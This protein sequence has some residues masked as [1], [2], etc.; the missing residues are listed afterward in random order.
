MENI[1][2]KLSISEVKCHTVEQN[3]EVHVMLNMFH[4]KCGTKSIEH[5]T[6]TQHGPLT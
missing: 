5:S 6:W 2:V 3:I 1:S 4:S